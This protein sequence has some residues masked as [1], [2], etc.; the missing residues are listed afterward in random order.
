MARLGNLCPST[1]A[2]CVALSMI[3][4]TGC[5]RTQSRYYF[6]AA[7]LDDSSRDPS[8]TFYRVTVTGESFGAKASLQQGFYS[9]DA[10]HQLFG[11]VSNTASTNSTDSTATT[12]KLPGSNGTFRLVYDKNTGTWTSTA[13]TLWTV[14]YG[15][16]A[17]KMAQ[18]VQA[19]ADSNSIAGALTALIGGQIKPAPPANSDVTKLKQQAAAAQKSASTLADDLTNI[20][21]EINP[22]ATPQQLRLNLLTAANEVMKSLGKAKQNATGDPAKLDTAFDAIQKAYD[23]LSKAQ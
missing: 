6:A 17:D 4:L 22:N 9:A 20:E 8:L 5:A 16:N 12:V 19:V 15:A 21:K 11:E 3:A 7:D 18:Q 13:D 23:N 1:L 10:L 14:F 2:M